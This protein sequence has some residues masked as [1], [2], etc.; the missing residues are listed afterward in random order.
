MNTCYRRPKRARKQWLVDAPE[1][2]LSCYDN[3]GKT[4]DRYTVLIGGS[5]HVEGLS[6]TRSVQYLGMSE[7]PSHPQGFSQWGEMPSC[8]RTVCGKPI[9]WLSL[10]KHIRTHVR[11]RCEE[12]ALV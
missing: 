6:R 7:A 12:A 1:Y 2:V 9:A 10:P 5:L 8:N 4:V 3:G 11:A